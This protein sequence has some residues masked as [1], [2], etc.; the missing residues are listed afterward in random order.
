MSQVLYSDG[1]D[2]NPF[3]TAY[4]L[5]DIGKHNSLPKI[6]RG[7]QIIEVQ[8]WIPA[9]KSFLKIFCFAFDFSALET[10]IIFPGPFILPKWSSRQI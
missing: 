10:F 3:S 2:S 4:Q 5:C 7:L 6:R 1:L 9:F 8:K